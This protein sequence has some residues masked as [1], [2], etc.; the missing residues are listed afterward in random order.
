[1]LIY[2][3][4]LPDIHEPQA[5]QARL[6]QNTWGQSWVDSI[7][8]FHHY[9]SNTHE[10]LVIISGECEVQFGGEKGPIYRVDTGDVILIP[11]GVAH[12]SLSMSQDFRCIGAYPFEV[13]TDMNCGTLDEYSKALKLIPHVGIPQQDP[14]FGDKGLLFN[15]WK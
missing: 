13:G 8:D 4:A 15:Y 9:H 5:I 3:Q 1:L 11:A 12:R 7:Y 10:V 14:I 2:Q 6:A